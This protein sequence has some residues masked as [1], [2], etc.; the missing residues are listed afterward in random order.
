M[1]ESIFRR[2]EKTS[3]CARTVNGFVVSGR[4]EGRNGEH[5]KLK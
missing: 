3:F 4:R 2:M 5:G 1:V